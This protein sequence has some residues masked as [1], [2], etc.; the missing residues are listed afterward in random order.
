M[1]R[2]LPRRDRGGGSE[3]RPGW[4]RSR[5]RRRSG[6]RHMMRFLESSWKAAFVCSHPG[7]GER[8]GQDAL[9]SQSK[10]SRPPAPR[11]GGSG[12]AEGVVSPRAP[13]S[14]GSGS[15]SVCP[16][17]A[18]T[19]LPGGGCCALPRPL[20]AAGSGNNLT[21]PP[22]G[23]GSGG[24]SPVPPS[25]GES[26]CPSPPLP[27]PVP[28]RSSRAANL[29]PC[30][31]DGAAGRRDGAGPPE[32]GGR[33]FRR[34][35]SQPGD[36]PLAAASC[37]RPAKPSARAK[38][39]RVAVVRGE[40]LPVLPLHNGSLPSGSS[41]AAP[42]CA[43]SFAAGGPAPA[44]TSVTGAPASGPRAGDGRSCAGGKRTGMGSA[45]GLPH[46]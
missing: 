45:G 2:P 44:A 38:L 21:A 31:R 25:L 12:G 4:P 1:R 42:T 14:S 43:R 17:A 33:Q 7:R 30:S 8:R 39:P 20:N 6:S 5:R 36:A 32:A 18:P 11:R 24:P 10:A 29:P 26:R 41:R 40:T 3:R 19:L 46:V 28:R 16:S 34:S 23:G 13:S 37:H 35:S 27:R 22:P 9:A 15:L